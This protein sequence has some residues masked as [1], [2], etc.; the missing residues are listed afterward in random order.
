MRCE[1]LWRSSFAAASAACVYEQWAAAETSYRAGIGLARAQGA[2]SGEIPQAVARL[3]ERYRKHERLAVAP[4]R[5]E[6]A[7]GELTEWVGESHSDAVAIR[8]NLAALPR[9]QGEPLKASNHARRAYALAEKRPVPDR[10]PMGQALNT[11]TNTERL[12]A[13]LLEAGSSR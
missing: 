1:S 7:L 10:P 2:T 9:D 4:T 5:L 3:S 13:W 11:R 6:V 12:V 8:G